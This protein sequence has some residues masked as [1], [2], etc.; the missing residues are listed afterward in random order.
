[1]KYLITAGA[2]LLLSILLLVFALAA[3]G[4]NTVPTRRVHAAASIPRYVDVAPAEFQE[5]KGWPVGLSAGYAHGIA[6]SD[7]GNVHDATLFH[8]GPN[9]RSKHF[10]AGYMPF[11]GAAH[12]NH[13][14]SGVLG[15]ILWYSVHFGG[16]NEWKFSWQNSI[17]GSNKTIEDK[18][19]PND[20]GSIFSSNCTGSPTSITRAEVDVTDVGFTFT[21]QT[22]VG[23][24]DSFLI[25]PSI[26]WTKIETS[27]RLDS[28]PTGNF[29]LNTHF[30]SPGLQLGYVMRFGSRFK[31]SITAM[32]GATSV[33]SFR[34]D[35]AD[36]MIMPVGNLRW[37]F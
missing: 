15:G 20:K 13:E 30:W 37:Q 9:F 36:R 35:K 29:T 6:F 27:N 4:C 3:T 1:M 21:A 5:E 24:R 2:P 8:I 7:T 26:Y 33:K 14:G 19:C 34:T 32:A 17:S 18:G 16:G 25:V 11:L 10:A 12:I 28:D 22:R 31:N 23:E